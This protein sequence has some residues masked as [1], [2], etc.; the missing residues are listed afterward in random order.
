[1]AESSKVF[2]EL[3][4]QGLK[5]IAAHEHKSII[6]LEDELGY[7]MEITRWSI[8]K[9]RQKYIPAN[10][11]NIEYLARACVRR[12]NMD[13][14][15]LVSFL[16]HARFPD[17]ET[18]MRE[19]FPE[20]EQPGSSVRRNL[21]GRSYERFVGR[22]GELVQLEQFL[23]PR[24]RLGVVCLIGIGGV[25]KTAL[26][27][28]IAHRKSENHMSLPPNERFEAIVWVTAK[29]TE[30]L[31]AGTMTRNPTFTDLNDLYRA[32][33]EVLDLPA[34]T[35]A[36]T[37][38]DREVIVARTL[39]EHRVLLILD[40]LEDI[41]DPALMVFL[42]DLP[43]PSKAIVTTRHRIDVAVPIQVRH[44]NESE[45][46]ELIHVECQR[47]NLVLTPEQTEKLLRRIGYLP[48]AIVRTLGRM[49]WRN[50]NIEAE[51]RQLGNPNNDIY[52][53]C[54]EKSI[55]MVRGKDPHKLF[56]ALALF[57]KDATRDALGHV[58]GFKEAILDRDEAISELEV[59][60]LVSKEG[61]R[62]SLEP[63]TKLK[64]QA[65]L[66][67]RPEFESEIR[68][69]WIEWYRLFIS[70]IEDTD[71]YNHH[72]VEASNLKSV[73][74]WLIKQK[75]MEDASWFFRR[76]RDFFLALGRWGVL[77]RQAEHILTWAETIEDTALLADIL[78][79]LTDIFLWQ[80]D[81][82]YGKSLHE[83][84]RHAA[85]RLR[86][87][88]LLAEVRLNEVKILCRHSPSSQQEEIEIAT[89]ILEVFRSYNKTEQ[90]VDTLNTLGNLHLKL[91]NFAEATHFYQ[92]GLELLGATTEDEDHEIRHLR[93]AL[94]G[95]LAH[96]AG[97]QGRFADACR[98]LRG[99]LK[100]FTDPY[101]AEAYVTLA[102]YEYELGHVQLA[103]QFRQ[104][105]DGYI[106]QFNM[107]RPICPED[108]EWSRS[109]SVLS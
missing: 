100:E 74:D 81:F 107:T 3:L 1:M 37:L 59:L 40:N 66:S 90:V 7:E 99:I 31:P 10:I 14:Q 32:T 62:F 79:P 64:A 6:A 24:H 94:Q 16:T 89:Q 71:H 41:D 56:M 20:K 22:E 9:W 2:G 83:R 30:L 26:A 12:A 27:L 84:I 86:D 98:T 57:S 53:F 60:S 4:T 108:E 58:V 47:H 76:T 101:L 109:F 72:R 43:A 18:L 28:E 54:F 23:S 103:Q 88:L 80:A 8:E 93:A 85:Q 21:P 106:K 105:A 33:A 78:K 39:A 35:R 75:R 36:L 67:I 49:A 63:L 102:L 73:I 19:L 11:K 46:R 51:L 42:R 17:K 61:M 92:E 68:E 38:A 104:K 29:Q 70:R 50:S 25:G 69:R 15:W 95:N 87:E 97:R 91:K 34:I 13:K 44:F 5:S 52:E 48:L 65:E 77:A 45:A 96:V 55:A 82:A